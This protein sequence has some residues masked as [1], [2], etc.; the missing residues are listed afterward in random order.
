[1]P[2]QRGLGGSA[3]RRPVRGVCGAPRPRICSSSSPLISIAERAST[4][5]TAKRPSSSPSSSSSP[6]LRPSVSTNS[7]SSS[8]GGD[9][10]TAVDAAPPPPPP[11]DAAALAALAAQLSD[12]RRGIKTLLGELRGLDMPPG[13]V[14]RYAQKSVRLPARAPA[15][16]QGVPVLRAAQALEQHMARA[17]G[18]GAAA[19][20]E[21]RSSRPD[22]AVAAPALSPGAGTSAGDAYDDPAALAALNHLLTDPWR[23]KRR[24]GGARWDEDDAATSPHAVALQ[25]LQGIAD[26]LRAGEAGGG[27][28][29]ANGGGG[30]KDGK[31]NKAKEEEPS[32]FGDLDEREKQE[33]TGMMRG[34]ALVGVQNAFWGSLVLS[35]IVLLLLNFARG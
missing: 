21:D 35:A 33:L 12:K 25:E 6:R 16:A 13:E 9:A 3:L 20:D 26:P 34:A 5:A 11:P 24:G 30:G 29:G 31:A 28:A 1:M 7:S 8:S 10:F 18:S 14:L 23:W 32:F 2:L 22:T 19:A 15:A 17:G 27:G 4:A